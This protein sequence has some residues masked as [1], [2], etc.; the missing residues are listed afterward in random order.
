[1]TS[2]QRMLKWSATSLTAAGLRS[3]RRRRASQP[4]LSRSDGSRR[5]DRPDSGCQVD[6]ADERDPAVDHDRLF[7]VAVERPLVRVERDVGC[8]CAWRGAGREPSRTSLREGRRAAASCQP[9]R[10]PSPRI[11]FAQPP[12]RED[13][14]DDQVTV[15]NK[16]EA[17]V[18]YQPVTWT[19]DRAGRIAPS[20]AG[21]VC[22]PSINTLHSVAWTRSAG[23]VA[24]PSLQVA[25]RA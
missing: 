13:A 3:A 12:R 16:R 14:E 1:M 4:S 23:S 17:G 22:A 21:R 18:K 2:C 19:Y 5:S 8:A 15:A 6:T 7:V 24:A 9:T 11:D 25:R 10:A 20:I